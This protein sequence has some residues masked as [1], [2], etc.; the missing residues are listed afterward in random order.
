MLTIFEQAALKAGRV[1]LEIYAEGCAV[2]V[3]ADAT[4][5]TEADIRAEEI[6]LSILR[7]A[8]PD[9]PIIAEEEVAAGIVPDISGGRFLLID[10]LDG[11]REFISR[12]GE[13]TVNIALIDE[14]VPVAGIVYAPVLATAYLGG[15][16]GAVKLTLDS[17]Q[18]VVARQAIRARPVATPPIAM[19]SRSHQDPETAACLQQMQV[20]ECRHIGSSLKFGLLAEGLADVYPRFGR[21]MEWDTAAGDA[22]LRAAGGA[23]VLTDGTPL[24]YGKRRRPDMAD[25]ANPAFIAWGRR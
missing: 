11:T 19:A 15:P 21:T 3:K 6:I 16:D 4:P 14:G 7:P 12:N 18:T 13:F 24:S 9:L 10:P 25:F 5:V 2:D 23:T 22:V 20:E 8:F 1:I 17:D